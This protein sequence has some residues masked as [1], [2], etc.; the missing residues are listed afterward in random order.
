MPGLIGIASTAVWIC[1]GL[2]L[3]VIDEAMACQ[4]NNRARIKGSVQFSGVPEATEKIVLKAIW[5]NYST[6][7]G[8]R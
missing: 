1:L 4:S 8:L 6:L 7:S 3:A 2:G 5:M